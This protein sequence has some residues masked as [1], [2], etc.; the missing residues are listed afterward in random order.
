MTPNSLYTY[1]NGA[2]NSLSYTVNTNCSGLID[3]TFKSSL[4]ALYDYKNNT[5]LYQNEF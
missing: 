4:I 1:I 5:D 3:Y 2:E